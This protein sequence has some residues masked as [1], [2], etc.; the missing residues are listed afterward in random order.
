[1]S[2]ILPRTR[3]PVRAPNR[4][5]ARPD[6]IFF[7]FFLTPCFSIQTP[8]SNLSKGMRWLNVEREC[9]DYGP[10]PTDVWEYYDYR[11]DPTDVG[12]QLFRPDSSFS[13]PSF[14]DLSKQLEHAAVGNF[15]FQSLGVLLAVYGAITSVFA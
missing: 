1:M 8:D 13:D 7:I 14:S 11:P 15:K 6:P 9:Y 5:E 4:Q 3:D 10:D 2:T 12:P